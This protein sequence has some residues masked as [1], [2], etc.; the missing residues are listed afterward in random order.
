VAEV[1]VD[2]FAALA[3]SLFDKDFGTP[4]SI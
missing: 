3:G 4:I 1:I 2:F